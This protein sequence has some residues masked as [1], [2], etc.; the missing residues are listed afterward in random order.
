MINITESTPLNQSRFSTL[1]AIESMKASIKERTSDWDFPVAQEELLTNEGRKTGILAVVRQ[2]TG[3]YLGQYRK[4]SLLPNKELVD[5]FESSLKSE[6]ISFDRKISVM[7]NGSRFT[8]SYELGNKI[9]VLGEAHS[10]VMHINNSYDGLR[11]V[12]LNLG[13][14]RLICLNGMTGFSKDFELN[15]RHSPKLNSSFIASKVLEAMKSLPNSIGQVE[16]LGSIKADD[17]VIT[18]VLGN[19]AQYSKGIIS[20]KLAMRILVA[21]FNPTN[22]EMPLGNNL[23]RLAQAGNRVLRDLETKRIEK[24]QKARYSFGQQ[25]VLAA[26]PEVSSYARHAWDQLKAIPSDPYRLDLATS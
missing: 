26:N 1:S 6:G 9:S 19:L 12:S 16:K 2:D 21:W 17:S 22:D 23:Y 4:Q 14:E 13:I 25:L 5:T 3:D 10:P 7:G 15:K 11:K 8:A 24:T 20:P 18:N